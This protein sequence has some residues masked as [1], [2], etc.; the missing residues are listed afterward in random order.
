MPNR[1]IGVTSMAP[2]HP[3]RLDIRKALDN[4]MVCAN[5]SMQPIY[6]FHH[7]PELETTQ[8]FN[9]PFKTQHVLFS[10]RS[11][12]ALLRLLELVVLEKRS[13]GSPSADIRAK[14]MAG[15][16]LYKQHI[17]S[18]FRCTNYTKRLLTIREQGLSCSHERLATDSERSAQ[19]LDLHPGAPP[20]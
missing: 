8:F 2:V 7:T 15:N 5:A 3:F 12:V 10:R 11:P 19:Q 1:W 20:C 13:Q 16:R 4:N 14:K 18:S 9:C 17:N 6:R